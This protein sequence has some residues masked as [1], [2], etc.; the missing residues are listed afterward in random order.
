[1]L[2]LKGKIIRNQVVF[3]Q[4]IN[5]FFKISKHICPDCVAYVHLL[6]FGAQVIRNQVA[7]VQIIKCILQI[8]KHFCP[9]SKT[10]L[11]AGLRTP[12]SLER[13]SN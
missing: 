8:L 5:V 9:D 6:H 1:M 12:A 2:H 7:F 13:Q 3:V 10:Y 4:I 11:M